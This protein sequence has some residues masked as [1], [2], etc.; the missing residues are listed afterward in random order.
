MLQSL[1]MSLVAV[2]VLAVERNRKAGKRPYELGEHFQ[3]FGAGQ[4]TQRLRR[5]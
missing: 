4:E 5:P 1:E 3:H 2:V